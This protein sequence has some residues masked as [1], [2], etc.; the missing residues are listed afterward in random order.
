MKLTLLIALI[1]I[2]CNVF[3]QSE[4]YSTR[5]VISDGTDTTYIKLNGQYENV[6]MVI[7]DTTGT[8]TL[9]AKVNYGTDSTWYTAYVYTNYNTTAVSLALATP[10]GNI[11]SFLDKAIRKLKLYISGGTLTFELKAKR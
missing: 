7:A 1:L 8:P 10:E 11:Y 9:T 6:T 3:A 4:T 5:D 2:S